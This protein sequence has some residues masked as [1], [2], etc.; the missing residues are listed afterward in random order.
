MY[1][2]SCIPKDKF[3]IAAIEMANQIG[4]PGLN[5]VLPDLLAWIQDANWPVA[6]HVASLLSNASNEILPH[7]KT[8][9]A[10]QDGSWKYWTIELVLKNIDSDILAELRDD[11]VRLADHPTQNDQAEEA[12]IAARAILNCCGFQSKLS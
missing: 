7:I 9:L 12:D 2:K 3:D 6:P 11:L 8:I 10:S 1:I 4:F 5:P